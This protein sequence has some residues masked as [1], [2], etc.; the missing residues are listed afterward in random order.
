VWD[1]AGKVVKETIRLEE[2]VTRNGKRHR[3]ANA[4]DC[5]SRLRELLPKKLR[6]HLENKP[7]DDWEANGDERILKKT[8]FKV[9]RRF[10]GFAT[11]DHLEFK[12]KSNEYRNIVFTDRQNVPKT[13]AIDGTQALHFVASSEEQ[14]A[15]PNKRKI[16]TAIM[17]C[18]CLSCR[19]K[20]E[21]EVCLFGEF[22]RA[23]D[24][25]TQEKVFDPF[26]QARQQQ[27]KLT[28]EEE[29]QLKAKLGADKI[30]VA[31]MKQYL[32]LRGL[33]VSGKKKELVDRIL[34][35]EDGAPTL[36][37]DCI[38]ELDNG[39]A[40]EAESDDEDE[41]LVNKE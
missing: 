18:S 7:W 8:P 36:A 37:V 33:R 38:E 27:Y 1:A 9:S 14:H 13:Q 31:A 16:C 25:W 23:K 26:A 39:E 17:P 28:S 12:E 2:M 32:R 6:K 3:F 21:K 24:H 11:E 41:E 29:L 5:F 20:T 35:H 30:T 10:V 19:G 15:D 40:P 4:W 34:S 22:W